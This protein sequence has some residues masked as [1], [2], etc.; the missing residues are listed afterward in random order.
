MANVP[1]ANGS[2]PSSRLCNEAGIGAIEKVGSPFIVTDRKHNQLSAEARRAELDSIRAAT[3]F[4]LMKTL[5]RFPPVC[6]AT[7]YDVACVNEPRLR[8][9]VRSHGH[10][11]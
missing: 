8:A 3:T 9:T 4:S 6:N 7:L 2:S 11:V 1:V 10:S 5:L